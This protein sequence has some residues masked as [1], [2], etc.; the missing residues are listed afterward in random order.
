MAPRGPNRFV[1]RDHDTGLCQMLWEAGVGR[2]SVAPAIVSSVQ[3]G[4]AGQHLGGPAHRPEAPTE[5]LRPRLCQMLCEAGVGRQIVGHAGNHLG[6]PVG[7]RRTRDRAGNNLSRLP[8]SGRQD[9]L[10][11]SRGLFRKPAHCAQAPT[12]ALRPRLHRKPASGRG[13]RCDSHLRRPAHRCVWW[14][15]SSA[16]RGGTPRPDRGDRDSISRQ[17]LIEA[18]DPFSQTFPIRFDGSDIRAVR[19][20]IPMPQRFPFFR[21]TR[22]RAGN[23]P[24]PSS[25]VARTKS[26][27][28]STI[29]EA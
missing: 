25:C 14:L 21:R 3:S 27:H 17:T 9:L 26:F 20:V 5:A 12:E 2:R 29:R 16:R 1:A 8:P 19:T 6:R 11:T 22:D 23:I 18:A 10:P 7:I 13:I 24:V 15:C 4:P 28:P